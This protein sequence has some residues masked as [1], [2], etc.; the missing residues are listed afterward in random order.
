MTYEYECKF[1]HGRFTIQ[2]PVS[3]ASWE[4]QCPKCLAK[5]NKVFSFTSNIVGK[6]TFQDGYNPAFGKTMT[7][8]RDVK[9]AQVRHEYATGEKIVQVGN[10]ISRTKPYIKPVDVEGANKELKYKL[11]KIH[12]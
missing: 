12:G 1:G 9:E 5:A 8:Y 10:D 11:R 7:K 4:R 2:C 6:G 3:K